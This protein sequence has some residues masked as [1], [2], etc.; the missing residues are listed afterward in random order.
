MA[1]FAEEEDAAPMLESSEYSILKQRVDLDIDFAGR[2][3]KGSTEITVQPLTK[4]LKQIKLHCRQCRPTTIQA[5]GI[6]AKWDYADP[7]R[8]TRMPE[9]STVHQHDMLKAKIESSIQPAPQAL[10][11]ITLP[12]KLK[13]QELQSD[14]VASSSN[15]PIAKAERPDATTIAETLTVTSAQPQGSQFA[16][17]KLSIEFEIKSF[18]DGVHWVGYEDGDRRYPYMYTKAEPWPGNSSCI[19]PCVDDTTSRSSWEISIR[20]PRTL[21]DAFKKPQTSQDSSSGQSESTI[22][23]DTAMVN[24]GHAGSNHDKADKHDTDQYLIDLAE[25]EVGSELTIVCTGNMIDDTVDSDDETRHTVA[26]NLTNPV[27]ARHIG[28]AIGPFEHVDLSKSRDSD[29]EERMGQSAI[30]VD[31]FCLPGRSKDLRNTCVP[32]AWAIDNMAIKFGSFPF[33]NYQMVFVDDFVH[34]TIATAGLSFC[35][36]SLLFPITIIEPIYRNTRILI[37]TLAEQWIGVNVIAKE[38]ADEWVVSGIA[39]FMTDAYMKDLSGNNEFR[40]QQKLAAEKVYELDVDRPSIRHL[41]ELLNLDRTI[42]DFVN[43]KSALVL[44]IL[45]TRLMKTTG[46]TGVQRIINKIFLNAKTGALVNGEVSTM[47]FQRTCERLGHNKLESFFRQWVFNSGC[48]IFHA[49]Q[50]FNKKKLVVEMTIVQRQLERKTKP[51]F[52]SNNFM[53]EI[54]EHVQEV[55]APETNP[56]FTGPMTIRI[57]EADGTPYEHI[58]EIKEAITRLEI[59]YNTKYKR[60]KRSRRQKERQLAEGVDAEGGTDALLFSLGNIYSTEE[61]MREWDLID[62]TEEQEVKMGLESYEWIR[63]DADFEWIGKIH[64]DMPVYMY[65][66]QLQQDRDIVAQYESLRYLLGSKP[67][68]VGLS[69]LVRTLMDSKYFWG[70]REMAAEGLAIC[71]RD[72]WREVGQYHLM[73]AYR[74]LFCIEGTNMPKSND[75][76]DRRTFVIQCAIPKAMAKLRDEDGKVPMRVR[77]FFVD[78]AQVQ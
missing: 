42:R 57:H 9:K 6:S 74:E 66:S 15:E 2:S 52:D 67:D 64:L 31:G 7:Y 11:T 13:I 36:S 4:D 32:I 75:F 20:C 37:R 18:R 68:H 65:V 28:F 10:L 50:R 30:R 5:G 26:F 17:I 12:P 8:R 24:G 71:A 60:L 44:F 40:W 51:P 70:I 72:K 46:Q 22:D 55:W 45:D 62:W 29:E 41:G 59:P 73:K 63:M 76:S 53:R 58:V 19:F 61:E 16:P 78:S 27:T 38:P 33:S 54:K 3:L 34:D 47:D 39:G 35:S 23:G 1:P 77:Q 69:I 21:G 48:P 25:D 56:V 43:I 14:Q 49:T